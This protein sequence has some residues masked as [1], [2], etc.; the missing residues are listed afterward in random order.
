MFETVDHG[1]LVPNSS[2]YRFLVSGS[3]VNNNLDILVC[4]TGFMGRILIKFTHYIVTKCNVKFEGHVIAKIQ[5]SI[6]TKWN[7]ERSKT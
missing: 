6:F 7:E 4:P 3:L 2:V 1:T 5:R